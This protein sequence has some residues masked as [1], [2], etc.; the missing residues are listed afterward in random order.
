MIH[1]LWPTFR[2]TISTPRLRLRLPREAELGGLAE[3]A[4]RGI[5]DP[6]ERPFL[7]PWT[8]GTAADRIRIVLQSHWDELSTWEVDD[9]SLGLGVFATSGEP[10][11]MVTLRA[12][13]FPVV[14]EV[15]TTSWLGL[16]HHGQGLGTEARRGLLTLAFDHLGA[17][18]ARTE[19]FQDN[20]ASQGVSRKLGYEHDGISRDAR[21]SEVLISDRLRLTRSRWADVPHTDVVV[22]GVDACRHMFA[23]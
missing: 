19:V 5:H 4:G 20:H 3:L 16:E 11:G 9:W 2:L 7:T 15:A 13:D 14:H 17:E 23:G 12:K 18:A 22:D 1:D 6:S 21:G 10:L 8:D